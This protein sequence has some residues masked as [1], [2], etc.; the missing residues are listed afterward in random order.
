MLAARDLAC[1]RGNRIIFRGVNL[2]VHAGQ[3]VWLRGSNGSGKTSLLRLLIGLGRPEAGAVLWQGKP[4]RRLM[5]GERA[6][7][8]VYVAHANALKDDLTVAE[9]LEFNARLQS[10]DAAPAAIVRALGVFGIAHLVA[11]PVRTLSQGQRR[12]VALAQL[13]LYEGPAL[14]ILDEPFDALDVQSV[15]RLNRTLVEHL[16]RGGAIVLTSHQPVA[17]DT[18]TPIVF[19]MDQVH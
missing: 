19:D 6:L 9:A 4:A 11:L 10:R 17:L 1:R 7:A 15:A 2:A 3:L 8:A 18:V 12:R 13:A 16:G 5:G 14:W